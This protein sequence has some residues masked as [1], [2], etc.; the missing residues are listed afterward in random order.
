MG[1][2]F[3]YVIFQLVLIFITISAI[4]TTFKFITDVRFL[5]MLGQSSSGLKM[6]WT[7]RT[8][9][10]MLV[11]HVLQDLLESLELILAIVI[12]ALQ[13]VGRQKLGVGMIYVLVS[14]QM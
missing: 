4:A 3:P 11:N 7:L 1:M 10:S 6:S 13:D 14:L 2:F 5:I 9:V 12:F 8:L